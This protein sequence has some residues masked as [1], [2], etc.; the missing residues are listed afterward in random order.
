MRQRAVNVLP[1]LAG[2]DGTGTPYKA[3]G[4]GL[5]GID[6]WGVARWVLHAAGKP[7]PRLRCE[8][9]GVEAQLVREAQASGSWRP[10]P[11]GTTIEVGDVLLTFSGGGEPHLATVYQEHPCWVVTIARGGLVH[12]APLRR[13]R[14]AE[15]WRFHRPS[16]PASSTGASSP[17]A[18]SSEPGGALASQPALPF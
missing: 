18:S 10:V 14:G 16:A 15:V 17:S 13:R 12:L 11:P 5:A 8:S 7:A 1:L 9:V 4:E 3:G 2:L 6:C